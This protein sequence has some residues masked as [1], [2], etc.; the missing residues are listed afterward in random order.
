[1]VPFEDLDFAKIKKLLAI[2]PLAEKRYPSIAKGGGPK[3][4]HP[5]ESRAGGA[6]KWR[7]QQPA[8]D[9][10]SDLNKGDLLDLGVNN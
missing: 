2:V 5:L 10:I 6:R 4:H 3:A 7:A 1:M 8:L 9:A